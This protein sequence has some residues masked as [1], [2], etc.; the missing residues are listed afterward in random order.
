MGDAPLMVDLFCGLG[1]WAEGGL[2]EG[3][4]VAGFDIERHIYGDH[5]YPGTLVIQDVRTLHGS[6]FRDAALLVASPP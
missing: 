4:R 1:G 2:A 5:K 3:Y 6:Q